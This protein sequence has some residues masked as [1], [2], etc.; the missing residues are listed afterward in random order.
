MNLCRPGVSF[1]GRPVKLTICQIGHTGAD[2]DAVPFRSMS[3]SSQSAKDFFRPLALGAPEPLREIPARP[4]R[5][6]HFFDPGHPKMAAK[7]PGMVGTGDVLLGNLEDA[8]KADSK[9]AAREGLVR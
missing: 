8:I 4:S 7:V 3:G 6:I 5:A 9:E 2:T 1:T